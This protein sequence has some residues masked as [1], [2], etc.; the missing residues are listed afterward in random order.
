MKKHLELAKA[1]AALLYKLAWLLIV[2]VGSIYLFF[3]GN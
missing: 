1:L 2:V 3:G